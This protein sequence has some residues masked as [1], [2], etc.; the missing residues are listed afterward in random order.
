MYELAC[1]LVKQGLDVSVYSFDKQI[2]G[3]FRI[4]Q[5]FPGRKFLGPLSTIYFSYRTLNKLL[6]TH[7]FDII[8]GTLVPSTCVFLSILNRVFSSRFRLLLTSNGM[9]FKERQYCEIDTLND[10]ALKYVA[11]SI[12]EFLDALSSKG[13]CH[14]VA[15]NEENKKDLKRLWGIDEHKISV[16]P[17]GIFVRKYSQQYNS[18]G[19]RSAHNFF[20]GLFIGRLVSRKRV[21]LLLKLAKVLNN[22]MKDFKILIVGDGYLR[23]RL[24]EQIQ[25]LGLNERVIL[26]GN[27][28]EARLITLLHSSDV[29]LF[30]SAYE[31]FG[32]VVL[33]AMASGLPVITSPIPAARFVQ[34]NRAGYVVNWNEPEKIAKIVSDLYFDPN[35]RKRLSDN[36]LT[37]SKRFD[38][39]QIASEYIKL[40]DTLCSNN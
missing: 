2:E 29:F 7:N 39:S 12:H 21:H 34:E 38:W 8:H 15:V 33:E 5:I 13:A 31:G 40:Y 18:S 1:E 11:W 23:Q 25:A 3:H 32:I 10:V 27:V 26:L 16:I 17:P 4:N 37:V 30:P 28:P 9:S 6:S 14:I 24:V 36:A 22:L 35:L 20:T 19:V